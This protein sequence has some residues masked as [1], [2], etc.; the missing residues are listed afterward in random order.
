MFNE[1]FNSGIIPNTWS[2]G[3][4]NPI[5]KDPT[6]DPRDAMNYRGI[7]IT[8]IVYKLFC[9]VLNNRLVNW[10]ELNN[11]LNFVMNKEVSDQVDVRVTI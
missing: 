7:T 8:S 4:I 6:T 9:S 2:R 11:G 1:C 5:L 10:F 3:I